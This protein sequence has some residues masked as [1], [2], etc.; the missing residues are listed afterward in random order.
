MGFKFAGTS[1][2][3]SAENYSTVATDEYNDGPSRV[4]RTVVCTV[5]PGTYFC[6]FWNSG[7]HDETTTGRRMCD[8]P[9]SGN[10]RAINEINPTRPGWTP[11]QNL[12]VYTPHPS[13]FHPIT[14]TSS[15]LPSLPLFS[16]STLPPLI[17]TSTIS[18]TLLQSVTC[19]CCCFWYLPCH[20]NHSPLVFSPFP[21]YVSLNLYSFLLYF[22]LLVIISFLVVSCYLDMIMSRPRL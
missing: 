2:G 7:T 21:R 5:T 4:K 17:I 19:R 8:G 3:N 18:P 13:I 20:L 11:F 1:P 6:H 10:R 22:C 9:S 15:N 16:T 12:T 14:S